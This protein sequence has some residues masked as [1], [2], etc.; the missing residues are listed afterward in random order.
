MNS[1]SED[2]KRTHLHSSLALGPKVTNFISSSLFRDTYEYSSGKY[3]RGSKIDVI[4]SQKLYY[5]LSLMVFIIFQT[6][7]KNYLTNFFY[8]THS[9][10]QTSLLLCDDF[11]TYSYALSSAMPSRNDLH[12]LCVRK[13]N[14]FVQNCSPET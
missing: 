4:L 6:Q 8:K 1:T 5:H 3:R 13:C 2:T 9:C 10:D 14:D 7:C 11:L 12:F